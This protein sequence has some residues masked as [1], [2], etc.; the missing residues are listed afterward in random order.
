MKNF[1][2]IICGIAGGLLLISF[3]ASRVEGA[4]AYPL[5]TDP[6]AGG[7]AFAATDIFSFG[8]NYTFNDAAQLNGNQIVSISQFGQAAGGTGAGLSV[9]VSNG[10]NGIDQSLDGALN[11][12]VNPDLPNATPANSV[13]TTIGN[14]SGKLENGNVI[15]YSAWFRSDAGNPINVDPQIQPVLKLEFWKEALSTNQDTNGG[16]V[17]PLFGD[18]V[19]DQDQ[20]GGA[21][22]I[23]AVDKAQWID[24]NGDGVVID[25]AAAGEGRVSQIF[26]DSWTLVESSYTV[27]DADWL[28][29][30]DDLYTVEDIEEI[31]A[32]M[33]L[34]D[35]V[36]SNLTG[37][38]DGGNLLIDN[39]LV[40]VFRTAAAVTPNTNPDPALSE[41][42][43]GDYNND[44]SVDAAD[45]VVWRKTDGNNPD[46]YDIWRANFGAMAPGGGTGALSTGAVP[47]P[48]TVSVVG[49]VVP[50][51]LALRARRL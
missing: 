32:V 42:L 6:N 24:F 49:L 28:G 43:Q 30:N 47:E 10:E 46:G 4:N 25:G 48:A 2:R 11:E 34:G 15:R 21:L 5:F 7:L 8:A 16:Q 39:V 50:L 20:H 29:I 41:G 14:P 1:M 31:R 22:G 9:P 44:G 13:F 40:E 45:Y 23:P 3:Q 38:G 35:F 26:T 37:D 12:I 17:Q 27:N 36:N 18:K 33:F 19:F 51:V